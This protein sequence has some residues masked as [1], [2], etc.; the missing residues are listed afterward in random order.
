M[1]GW[2]TARA[3]SGR[4]SGLPPSPQSGRWRGRI[5]G[6]AVA[7]GLSVVAGLTT[8]VPVAAAAVVDRDDGDAVHHEAPVPGEPID[9]FRPPGSEW[10]AGNRGHEYA[11]GRGD[12]V[13]ASAPGT[14]VFAGHVGGRLHVTVWHPDGLRTT[15]AFLASVSVAEGQVVVGGTVVGT[16]AGRFHFTVRDAEDRYL[17]PLSVLGRKVRWVAELVP[18]DDPRVEAAARAL[19]RLHEKSILERLG[20]WASAA[21]KWVGDRAEDVGRFAVVVALEVAH[22]VAWATMRTIVDSDEW[23]LLGLRVARAMLGAEECTPDSVHP[24][25]PEG[26]RVA[27]LVGGLDSGHAGEAFAA[28]DLVGLG[29]APTDVVAFSYEGGRSPDPSLG[30]LRWLDPVPVTVH[31]DESTRRSV[32]DSAVR[33]ADLLVRLGDLRPLAT[34]EVYGFSLGG[35]VAVT[36]A[37]DVHARPDPPALAILTFASPH[38]GLALAEL[39]D[40]VDAIPGVDALARKLGLPGGRPVVDD[41]ADGLAVE[42]PDGLR[43]LSVA[44]RSDPLVPATRSRLLGA[45]EAIVDTDGFD[46]D[47]MVGH[48]QTHREVELFLAGRPKR[49]RPLLTRVADV[50]VPEAIDEV[51]GFLAGNRDADGLL[52]GDGSKKKGKK[53]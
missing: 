17:D 32:A 47:S 27:V 51:H 6:I 36:A 50:V 33:L 10:G 29:V 28:L 37:V 42:V 44:A 43:V 53:K 5:V 3:P 26:D 48:S 9:G 24:P 12:P 8:P 19:R 34:L 52:D 22:R 20:G 49:C 35:M 40:A 16:S 45:T 25:P 15:Y 2:T 4:P 31:D 11:T 39:L 7:V 18:H 13:A 23:I 46:H 30:G 1:T 21:G 14:V 38:G 41:L